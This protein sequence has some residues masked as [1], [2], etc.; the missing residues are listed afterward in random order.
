[1]NRTS[2]TVIHRCSAAS[3]TQT[4]MPPM[5]AP[6]GRMPLTASAPVTTTATSIARC[7]RTWPSSVD[8]PGHR[9]GAGLGAAA[10]VG[11]RGEGQQ[12]QAGHHEEAGGVGRDRCARE[13]GGRAESATGGQQDRA[14]E[15]DE[16][17]GLATGL[18]GA[19]QGQGGGH[20]RGGDD[21][22]GVQ[23]HELL[24]PEPGPAAERTDH[25]ELDDDEAGDREQ[26]RLDGEAQAGGQQ[27]APL[28]Q[29]EDA[30]D[31]EQVARNG[32]RPAEDDDVE[33]IGRGDDGRQRHARGRGQRG[34]RQQAPAGPA[35]PA[36]G[37]DDPDE[38]GDDQ[39]A[40][41]DGE[42]TERAQ[43]RRARGDGTG[44]DRRSDAREQPP[45]TRVHTRSVGSPVPPGRA[46][47]QVASPV[48]VIS[49]RWL[50]GPPSRPIWRTCRARRWCSGAAAAPIPRGARPAP[51][52]PPGGRACGW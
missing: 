31:R 48:R 26:D 16:R 19:Q 28:D 13:E 3:A 17:H 42:V 7:G 8:R 5:A 4:T 44:E 49:R 22:R 46:G 52:R 34:H 6:L 45:S 10:G 47:E 36:A 37:R 29:Q 9:G 41:G 24:D 18:D 2:R 51:A 38:D 50:P 20:R 11:Q 40:G 12:P 33:R 27:P 39:P 23:D 30:D 32:G 25:E 21:H 15:Q 35:L 14:G 43:R 1:M